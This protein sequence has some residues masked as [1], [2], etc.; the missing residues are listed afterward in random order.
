MKIKKAK[1]LIDEMQN[2]VGGF[3]ADCIEDNKKVLE[4][5]FIEY[6][7]QFLELAYKNV[8][9]YNPERA[10]LA[11]IFNKALMLEIQDLIK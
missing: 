2:E 5:K 1:E 3:F 10:P 7:N 8:K 4:A 9:D 6:A 11:P